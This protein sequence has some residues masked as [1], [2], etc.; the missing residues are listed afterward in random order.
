LEKYREEIVERQGDFGFV[1]M[2]KAVRLSANSL[3]N[4]MGK[5]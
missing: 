2:G 1:I 5:G 3:F 4:R